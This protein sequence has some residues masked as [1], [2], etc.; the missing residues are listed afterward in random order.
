V[1]DKANCPFWLK[2][3]K[4]HRNPN[5]EWKREANPQCLAGTEE[6]DERHR[7]AEPQLR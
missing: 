7:L 6:N 4:W 1:W 2:Y 5:S 3:G